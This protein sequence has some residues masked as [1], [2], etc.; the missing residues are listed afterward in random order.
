MIMI[1]FKAGLLALYLGTSGWRNVE[2]KRNPSLQICP[3][4][5]SGMEGIV[6]FASTPQSEVAVSKSLIPGHFSY[7]A[8]S[9]WLS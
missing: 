1:F 3:Y 8:I 2:L 9:A 4:P 5:F 7:L 6:N